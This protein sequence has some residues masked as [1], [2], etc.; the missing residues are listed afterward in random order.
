M[1]SLEQRLAR[2]EDHDAIRAL[3]ARYCRALDDG[4]WDTL[5]SLFTDDGEFLGLRRAAGHTSLRRFFAGLARSGLT[6]Y[7]HH[8][9]NLEITLDDADPDRRSLCHQR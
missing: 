2:L 6:A 7:W 3:D 9:T 8:V 5:V 1:T 4:D